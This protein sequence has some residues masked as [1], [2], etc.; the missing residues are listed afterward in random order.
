MTKEDILKDIREQ[1]ANKLELSSDWMKICYHA[2]EIIL[3]LK[4]IISDFITK[5]K[6][7]ANPKEA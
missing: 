3:C 6:E 1:I 4:N 7:N 2:K 5:L